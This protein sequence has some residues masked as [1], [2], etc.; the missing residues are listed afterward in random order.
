MKTTREEGTW[1]RNISEAISRGK[2]EWEQTVDAI[3]DIITIMEADLRI[4]RAN[5]AAHRLFGYRLGELVGRRCYEVFHGRQEPCNLCPAA[6]PTENG[7]AHRYLVRNDV[8]GRVFELSVSKIPSAD[9]SISRIVQ[10]AR[11]VTDTLRQEEERLRLSTA[12]GQ[13]S[14]MVV[15]TDVQGIIRYVNP[16]FTETTGFTREEAIGRNMN[17]LRSGHHD[18]A[19]YQQ[20]WETILA[21][22]VWKGRLTNRKKDGSLFS[23]MTTISPIIDADRTVSAFVAV[24]R[25][26]SRE[27]E[28]EKQL[29]Q[30]V[31]LEAI[32][33]L[34]GGIAHDFNNILSAILGYAQI[35]KGQLEEGDPL[36]YPLDHIIT[37]GDRAAELISQILTFSRQ[38]PGSEP[39]S[40]LKAQSII[41]EALKLLRSSFPSTIKLTYRIDADGPAIMADAGQIHQ[42]IMNLCTNARQA[43]ET[44][45]GTI[46][47]EA[48]AV[49]QDQSA[50]SL[51]HPTL[52]AGR[53]LRI[54][55]AD[56]GCGMDEAT[57][58]RIFD[59][60]F[61]TKPKDRGTGLG[62][63]VVHGIVKKHQGE[64]GVTSAPGQGTTFEIYLPA[65][66]DPKENAPEQPAP[67]P[68]GS[69]RIMLVDDEQQLTDLL[70][71][72]LERLG[73]QVTAFT[74]S[75][76]AVRFF[77]QNS[78][79][80]DL[81]ITDM[82]MP[83]MTG[84]E[85]AREMLAL[86]PSLPIILI[87]GYHEQID[88]SKALRIGI[89]EFIN[90]PLRRNIL[91]HSIREILDHGLHPDH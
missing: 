12:I 5:R 49:E 65:I 76:E 61:T 30:A 88:R 91:A 1:T 57:R 41:K 35:A 74:D 84:T 15:I 66:A 27:E 42:V 89:R 36:S 31:K 63:A 7:A 43:I 52:P 87:T 60:F 8:L 90:K 6:A 62:L 34:A 18:Q 4:I 51:P 78:G 53:Y 72:T 16:A 55:V 9:G 21:G 82:T 73:Y 23:E 37:A 26:I 80:F 17:L 13:T 54:S 32:G 70:T 11:D 81:V 19:F 20:L 58:Q 86:R 28:L 44:E 85:L 2:H 56:S 59:P 69:E 68:G 50:N 75:L 14:E 71:T 29:Q 40:P 25:D 77:R 45:H 83:N 46:H 64:I 10:I 47:V 48:T 3:D 38:D 22:R 39:L 79:S 33:T 67:V 24:K